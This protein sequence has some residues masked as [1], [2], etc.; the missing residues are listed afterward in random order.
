MVC[1]PVQIVAKVSRNMEMCSFSLMISKPKFFSAFNTLALGASTGN[2]VD[3]Y[4]KPLLFQQQML[5][6]LENPPQK[7]LLQMFQCE[8]VLRI[9]H[10]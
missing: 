4:F 1:L 3:K 5:Q 10:H 2:F 6:S 7:L 9:L 8:N